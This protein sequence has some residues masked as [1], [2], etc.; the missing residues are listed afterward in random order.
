MCGE[1][2]VWIFAA[3]LGGLK[4]R[5]TESLLVVLVG[6]VDRSSLWSLGGDR[7]MPQGG[8]I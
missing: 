2:S 3:G 6:S 7:Y 1:S 4:P 8:I 5:F